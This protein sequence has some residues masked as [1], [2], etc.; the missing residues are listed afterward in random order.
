MRRSAL[1]N[2]R[3]ELS[4]V[5][6]VVAQY[7]IHYAQQCGFHLH[8]ENATGK[9]SIEQDLRTTAGWSRM[10]AV[11]A[12]VGSSVAQ[13]LISLTSSQCS[14]SESTRLAVERFGLRYEGLLT[15]PNQV[16]SGCTPSLK[17]NLFINNRLVQCT[18]IKR[19][20]ECAYSVVISRALSSHSNDDQ[21]MNRSRGT[22]TTTSSS[23]IRASSNSNFMFKSST[24][25]SLYVYLNI[26]LP[27]H[28]LDVN[29]HPTKAEVH[30]L[31]EDEIVNGLQ[32]AVEHA[33]LSS[34]QIQTFI[35]N[36]LS[37]SVTFSKRRE[38]IG[39]NESVITNS[40]D[41]QS[42]QSVYRPHEK[43][44]IDIRQQQLERFL[45][46]P[47]N[48]NANKAVSNYITSK[49]GTIGENLL[50][51]AVGDM[52]PDIEVDSDEADEILKSDFQQKE[53][54]FIQDEVN[55]KIVESDVRSPLCDQSYQ[56]VDDN[57]QSEASTLHKIESQSHLNITGDD[58]NN[59]M[60]EN[61]IS[62]T[63][64]PLVKMDTIS[65]SSQD[66][67]SF[68]SKSNTLLNYS[69]DIVT[70][71]S[72]SSSSIFSSSSSSKAQHRKVYLMSILA[73]KRNLECDCDR[74]IK[75]I[76]R[77][78]KFIGLIDETSCLAQH[79]T[80]LLLIRLKPLTQAFFYQLLLVNFANHGEIILREP[81]SLSD[82]LSIGHEYLRKSSRLLADLSTSEF[83][84]EATVTLIK[85]A[86][87]LW[88][89]FSIK[90]TTDSN[91]NNVLTGIPLVIANYIPDLDKLPIYITKLVTQ[92]SWSVESVCFENICRI[93]AE[94]Y[95][96][97]PSLFAKY[98]SQ[99][100]NSSTS[101]TTDES[102]KENS[103]SPLS[104]REWMI[105]HILWPVLC[106]SFLPSRRYPDFDSKKYEADG[107]MFSLQS[108][109]IRLTS[110]A[111]LYKVF[112]RC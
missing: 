82:L 39:P 107:K 102:D 21:Q 20:V 112:E 74:S 55:R 9:S 35:R 43:V 65:S 51:K 104:S 14:S 84:K 52:S 47:S 77:S 110:L 83:I 4:R 37:T 106:S 56:T 100:E 15:A 78:C 108:A 61:T 92:V 3:E 76:L 72:P 53:S 85:H 95:S 6:D 11:R 70:E 58:D 101:L 91:G 17:F 29:V 103:T 88:D 96:I 73:L 71:S 86:P 1:K 44:R 32:D 69:K 7:A 66:P 34:A 42:S 109:F 25:N 59:S 98:S 97:S 46:S 62:L 8:F 10:D 68:L 31:H 64:R 12:V 41:L 36:P 75:V 13:N 111:D 24:C 26:Q 23:A 19:V 18:P 105:Q 94:Y 5:T 22:S 27:P 30:F 67:S 90:I 2:G 16:S 40:E 38:T 63:S 57:I 49:T 79:H 50:K 93:T 48:S 33:L 45:P 60:N 87:M 89:Y 54:S 80:E 99:N 28:T 81:A